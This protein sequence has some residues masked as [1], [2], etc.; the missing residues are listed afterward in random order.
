[1]AKSKSDPTID[2]L[3]ANQSSGTGMACAACSCAAAKEELGRILK[4]MRET[5][6]HVATS[7]IDARLRS[8]DVRYNVRARANTLSRHLHQHARKEWEAAK[9]LS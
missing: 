5:G 6:A 4:A 2:W 8:V 3:L 1:M 7:T 9:G